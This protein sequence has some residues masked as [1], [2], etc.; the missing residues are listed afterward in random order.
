MDRRL[1]PG[2]RE[3]HLVGAILLDHSDVDDLVGAGRQV[4][5]HVVGTDRQLAMPAVDDHRQADGPRPPVVGQRVERGADRAPGVEHV[6]DQD[7]RP[8]RDV[9]TQVAGA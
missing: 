5:A 8:V 3:D 2:S 4:L 7:H 1:G 9:G 6:V